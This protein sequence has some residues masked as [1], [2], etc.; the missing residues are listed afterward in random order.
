MTE[1]TGGAVR[2]SVV[3]ACR[4]AAATLA[5]QL[6]AL[7]AQPCPVPWEVLLCDDRSRDG[8]PEL[9]RRLAAELGDRLPLRVLDV[10]AP[11]GRGAA[12]NAGAARARGSWL[13]FCDADDVVADDYLARMCAALTRHAFVAARVEPARLNPP[14]VRRSR[15]LDQTTGLQTPQTPDGAPHA[16]AGTLGIHADVFRRLGG[17]DPALTCLEDTDLCRRAHEAG[18]ALVFDPDVVVHVRLRATRPGMLAQGWAH[19]RGHAQLSGRRPGS[20][21]DGSG[22]VGSGPDSSGADGGARSPAGRLRGWVGSPPDLGHLVWQLGWHLGSWAVTGRR[23]L[24]RAAGRGT[25]RG[26][27]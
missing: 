19:G 8:G 4:D 10:A 26:T 23:E 21:P 6:T 20:G 9:A 15:D 13:A 27:R 5:E 12:R 3:I 7:A 24:R 11:G 16:G 2:L 1:V 14:R 17:F 18:V 22:S 25:R